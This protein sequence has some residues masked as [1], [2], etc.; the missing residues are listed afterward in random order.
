MDAEHDAVEAE[1]GLPWPP[2]ERVYPSLSAEREEGEHLPQR[3][4]QHR[5]H[6]SAWIGEPGVVSF[7]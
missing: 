7:A 2:L 6:S 5:W 1:D 4:Y 3:N